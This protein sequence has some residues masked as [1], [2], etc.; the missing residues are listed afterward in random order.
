[1]D[2]NFLLIHTW[3][4]KIL[5]AKKGKKRKKEKGKKGEKRGEKRG[6]MISQKGNSSKKVTSANRLL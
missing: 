2:L 4:N 1:M 5:K 3:K 6:E